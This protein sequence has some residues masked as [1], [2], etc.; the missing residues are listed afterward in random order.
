MRAD[1]RAPESGMVDAGEPRFRQTMKQGA[2]PL[3]GTALRRSRRGLD[4]APHRDHVRIERGV[5]R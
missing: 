3:M 2:S 5:G 1:R 4:P